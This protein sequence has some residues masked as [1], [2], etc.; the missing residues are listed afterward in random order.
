MKQLT[1]IK[2][3]VLEWREVP[4]PKLE[5]REDALVRPFAAARCDLDYPFLFR[6]FHSILQRGL[7][8]H[9]MDEMTLHAWGQTPFKGPFPYGH[10]CVAEIVSCGD[11]V[12]NFKVGDKVIVP[13]QIS[14]GKCLSC[15]KDLTGL[16][17]SHPRR[18]YS[19]GDMGGN[20]GGAVSDI[21]RVPYAD[22]MLIRIPN[23]VD[24][25]GLA[26]ASDNIP[27]GYRAVGPFL[28]TNPNSPVL[29]VGGGAFSIALYAAA[30]AVAMG[31][32]Q[33]D[34]LDTDPLRLEIAKKVGANPIDGKP[35]G[36]R[37]SYPITVD[38]SAA[39][40]GLDC[41]IRST[42]PGGVSTSIG[43]YYEKG[44]PMPLFEMWIKQLNFRTGVINARIEIPEILSLV[45]SGL[46]KPELV[47]T[48]LADWEDAE[49]AFLDPTLKVVVHRKTLF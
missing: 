29:I 18:W 32:P 8:R 45:Q 38:A 35:E 21:V 31:S 13:F 28:K 10:E 44:T 47:T 27:D 3:G 43:I 23:G 14:C 30:I 25:I 48:K 40:A 2:K 46:L 39:P 5:S 26:S 37:G 1:F 49:K 22:S 17:E 16:C 24:P 41:A 19:Y 36:S 33:V 20:W 15:Q 11:N 9:S 12:R 6:D 4:D 34:Y 42:A 7:Q